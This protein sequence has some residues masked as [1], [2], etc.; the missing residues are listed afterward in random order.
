MK[1]L[2]IL[3]SFG[4]MIGSSSCK[5]SSNPFEPNPAKKWVI[6]T[7]AGNGSSFFVEGPALTAGFRAPLDVVVSS[8]GHIYVADGLNH[9]IRKIT[10]EGFVST[11][12][13]STSGFNDGHGISA[14]FN[15]PFGLGI[16]ELG[17]IYVADDNNNR[18]RKIS[19]E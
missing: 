7:I 3:V 6:T 15:G 9:C 1:P 4:L 19:L 12:A 13:G 11:I 16:D 14:K 18:I 10:P 5:K 17:N 8:N 2:L